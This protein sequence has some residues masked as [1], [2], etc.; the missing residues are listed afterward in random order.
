MAGDVG[1]DVSGGC[2]T[3]HHRH[4]IHD[5]GHG[6]STGWWWRLPARAQYLV[7]GAGGLGVCLWW[8]AICQCLVWWNQ[9]HHLWSGDW[10]GHA[11]HCAP[12]I[13]ALT[14]SGFGLSLESQNGWGC[15]RH[16]TRRG[17][18]QLFTAFYGVQY[19]TSPDWN[20]VGGRHS[21]VSIWLGFRCN[22]VGCHHHLHCVFGENHQLAQRIFARCQHRWLCQQQPGNWLLIEL[23]NGQVLHQWN[24]WGW[25]LRRQLKTTGT[26]Q[27]EKPLVVVCFEWRTGFDH[28]FV[29]DSDD[30]VGGFGGTKRWHECGWLCVGQCFHDAAVHPLGFVGFCLSRDQDFND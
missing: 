5:Q 14:P 9:G 1:L 7:V 22:H 23:W 29:H 27:K 2:Q 13:R 15:Q 30:V 18:Y 6:G 24:L 26:G 28:Q 17:R 19:I 21:V 20:F 10:T 8:F 4:A 3:G 12:G 11:P 25:S 16:W